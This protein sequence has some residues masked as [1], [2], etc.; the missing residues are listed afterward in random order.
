LRLENNQVCRE[1][2]T[3]AQKNPDLPAIVGVSREIQVLQ[4]RVE[5]EHQQL[6]LVR[7]T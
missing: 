4:L 7:I 3:T 6:M 5:R 2:P 1:T